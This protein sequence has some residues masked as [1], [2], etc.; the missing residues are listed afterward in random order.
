MAKKNRTALDERFDKVIENAEQQAKISKEEIFDS[1][2]Y[3]DYCTTYQTTGKREPAV[4]FK[5]HQGKKYLI[6]CNC[7]G[8]DHTL[9][10][11]QFKYFK[12]TY[13]NSKKSSKVIP[14]RPDSEFYE[15][16]EYEEFAELKFK[17]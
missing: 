9:D 16:E 5:D 13:D 3:N 4:C 1:K 15:H 12:S 17:Y 8:E 6:Y 10:K 7:C 14:I 11:E 2:C